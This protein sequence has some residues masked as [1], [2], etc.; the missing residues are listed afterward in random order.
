MKAIITIAMLGLATATF[1]GAPEAGRTDG[2]EGSEYGRGGYHHGAQYGRFYTE[3]FVGAAP[4]DFE[5]EGLN[6]LGLAETDIIAGINA[7][8][9][10]ED[11]LAFQLG[12]GHI[13]DQAINLYSGGVRSAYATEPFN[14]YFSLDAELYSPNG[15]DDHFGIVPGVGVE[16]ILSHRLRVGLRYQHDFIFSDNDIRIN[17][18]TAQVQVDF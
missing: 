2:P 10:I 7:G 16:V 18:F 13:S 11:W 5:A 12:F 6:G 1:A 14:Y 9:M 4:V 8:Y 3:G 15:G 17:R